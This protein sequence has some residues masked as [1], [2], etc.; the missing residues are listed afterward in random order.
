MIQTS[1]NSSINTYNTFNTFNTYN[2]YNMNSTTIHSS[3]VNFTAKRDF[4]FRF[5][6]PNVRVKLKMDDESLYSTTDQFT[7]DRISKDILK[8]LPNTSTITDA[9]SC[10]GGTAYSFSQYFNKVY[11]IEIDPRRY[12]LLVHNLSVLMKDAK[13]NVT[14]INNDAL[15][16]CKF[17]K[18]DAIFIDPPWGGPDYKQVS[19]M[20]LYLSNT[21]LSIICNALYICTKYIVIKVPIN[22]DEELFI[23]NTKSFMTLVHKNISLRKMHLL[24][25]KTYVADVA[26][27]VDVAFKTL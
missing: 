21:E 16:S 12:S 5:V 14:C 6:Q 18:Q 10:I 25:F 8:F 20:S 27:V 11:A 7:A 1:I 3:N 2:P 4:L 22:F 15:I 24:I 9:T 26:A 17:L 13:I 19:K 23:E